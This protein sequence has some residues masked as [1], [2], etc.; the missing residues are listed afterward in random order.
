ML[1]ANLRPLLSFVLLMGMAPAPHRGLVTQDLI[2]TIGYTQARPDLRF[3]LDL[4][5]YVVAGE[6]GGR[7]SPE[8]DRHLEVSCSWRPCWTAVSPT[9][10]RFR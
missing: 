10:S 5:H 1:E 9:A 4:S 8:A 7:V 6:I 2:R 3:D